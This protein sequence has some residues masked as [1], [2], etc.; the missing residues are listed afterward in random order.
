VLDPDDFMAKTVTE[1]DG[2]FELQGE[3]SEVFH[4]IEPYLIVSHNCATGGDNRTVM[5]IYRD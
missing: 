5:L 4:S 3:E 1:M 2:S